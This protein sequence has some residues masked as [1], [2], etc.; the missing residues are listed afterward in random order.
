MSSNSSLN[1]PA[2]LLEGVTNHQ[3]KVT[4]GRKVNATSVFAKLY[5]EGKIPF[6]LAQENLQLT[7]HGLD[8]LEDENGVV[9]HLDGETIFRVVGE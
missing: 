4:A 6:K 5:A 3:R 9:W 8:M 2:Y 7:D 1:I